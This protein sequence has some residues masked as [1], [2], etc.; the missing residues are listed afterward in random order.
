[1]LY[2]DVNGFHVF[3]NGPKGLLEGSEGGAAAPSELGENAAALAPIYS[4]SADHCDYA[5]E[6]KKFPDTARHTRLPCPASG[7]QYRR[8]LPN[9]KI[10][11]GGLFLYR[12]RVASATRQGARSMAVKYEGFY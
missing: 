5:A 3:G 8:S 4:I 9:S 10:Q 6:G 7:H 1:M 12:G 11:A 2:G